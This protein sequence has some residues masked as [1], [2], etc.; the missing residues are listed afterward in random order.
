MIATLIQNGNKLRIEVHAREGF[1]DT[2]LAT[3][4]K[5]CEALE[6]VVNSEVFKQMVLSTHFTSTNG[7]SNQQILDRIYSGAD[8]INTASDGDIDVHVIMYHKANRTVGYTYPNTH[9]TW[10][11]RK[12]YGEVKD[13]ANNLIHEYLHKLSFDHS[14]ASEHTSVPYMVGFI[15]ELLIDKKLN[16]E[17]KQKTLVCYRSWRNLWLKQ[18]CEWV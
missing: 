14:S 8:N 11:N 10:V 18:T 9:K 16:T 3:H 12:F 7:L 4:Q 5:A 2:E 6:E 17:P 1:T 15:V 13:I